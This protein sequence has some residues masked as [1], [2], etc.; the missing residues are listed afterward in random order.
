MKTTLNID[1]E[2][3]KKTREYALSTGN[4]LT[5]VIEEGLWNVFRRKESKQK[6]KY[7]L[8]WQTVKGKISKG[9]D[10]SDRDSLYDKMEGR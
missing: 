7:K 6:R 5:K 4:T 1:N 3:L 10:L 9:V 8:K 2:L